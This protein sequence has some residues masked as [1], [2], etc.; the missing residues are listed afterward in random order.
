MK[1]PRKS[2]A[3]MMLIMLAFFTSC[4]DPF[5][6]KVIADF[7]FAPQNPKVNDEVKFTSKS[8]N[9]N[10]FEWNFGDGFTSTYENPEH[11]YTQEGKF[12][13]K[14]VVTDLSGNTDTKSREIVVSAPDAGSIIEHKEDIKVD[15]V[16]SNKYTHVITRNIEV[17]D[18]TLTI[19]PGTVVKFNE[20]AGLEFGYSTN[21]SH[22]KLIAQGTPT[23]RITFTANKENPATGSWKW[24]YFGKSASHESIME[25][26][27]ISYGGVTSSYSASVIIE[28][29][30]IKFNHNTVSHSTSK[31]IECR[32]NGHFVSFTDNKIFENTGSSMGIQSKYV[33]TLGENNVIA[34]T[35]NGINISGDVDLP[36]DFLWRNHG[37]KY[38]V[39]ND[40]N[41]GSENGTSLTIAKGVTIA[42]K[43]YQNFSVGY[44]DNKSGKLTAIGTSTEPI[45]FVSAK[46]NSSSGDWHF[47]Y[48]GE[49]NDP[50]SRMEYC[51]IDAAGGYNSN[52]GA[53]RLYNTKISF[54]NCKVTNSSSY[55]ISLNDNSSFNSFTGNTI[56]NSAQ[57]SISIPAQWA[58]TIG[59]NNNIANDKFGIEIFDDFNHNGKSFTWS[60][61]TCPYTIVDD[62]EI[63]SVQGCTLT[64]EP[65]TTIKLAQDKS[66]IVAY[67]DNIS[68]TLIAKGTT[69]NKITFTSASPTGSWE[70][71]F[72]GQGSM[73][74][75]LLEYCN[76]NNG[77]NYNSDS[78]AVRC[79]NVNL[80]N[81]P[82]VRNCY[83]TNSKS[84]GISIYNSSPILE[85]NTF[86]NNAGEDVYYD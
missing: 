86:E 68:G 62:V 16:W 52:S 34:N 78:G 38:T 42:F 74:D 84:N 18:A 17:I 57:S 40:V 82:T 19:E 51:E 47:V 33:H 14:L 85:N 2:F 20:Y 8:L 39:L 9:A 53:V 49:F 71:I 81:T 56:S 37:A 13:V 3:L 79:S 76:I 22:S 61:Q 5:S 65:G 21:V 59:T 10:S 48:F 73:S 63:G 30:Q 15:E 25:Y 41:V 4:D 27:D 80:E 55:G 83:I 67:R 26:C 70:Y 77:G 64:I 50:T 72:F 23:E 44:D 69:S 11:T 28:E 35:K 58:H 75:N 60:K 12:V 45:R 54:D 29:T 7:V 31:G 36:G 6:T 1:N 32:N 43:E 66:L 24:I 46:A